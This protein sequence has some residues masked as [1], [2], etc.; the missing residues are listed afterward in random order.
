MKNFK[1]IKIKSGLK[2]KM[3]LIYNKIYKILKLL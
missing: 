3:L 1:I 2:V